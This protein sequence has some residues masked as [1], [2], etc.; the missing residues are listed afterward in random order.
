MGMARGTAGALFKLWA[1]WPWMS[2][3]VTSAAEQTKAPP[4]DKLVPA[5]TIQTT[6]GITI[7]APPEVIYPS[8]LQIGVAT[9]TW[10]RS[11]G[12]PRHTRSD[13]ARI[14]APIV[15][16]IRCING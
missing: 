10:C 3:G 9:G 7:A 13:G 5:P 11:V 12:T 16:A 1:L 6:K 2:R 8:L 14:P 15:P 4:G